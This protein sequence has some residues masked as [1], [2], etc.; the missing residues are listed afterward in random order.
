VPQLLGTVSIMG[1]QCLPIL[2]T[3]L[4]IELTHSLNCVEFGFDR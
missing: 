3:F 1:K 4:L 2:M